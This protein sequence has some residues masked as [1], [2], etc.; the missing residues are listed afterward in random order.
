MEVGFPGI[1]GWV[2]GALWRRKGC[3]LHFLMG[4]GGLLHSP[5]MNLSV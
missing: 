4:T 1:G 3:R 5:K 2:V